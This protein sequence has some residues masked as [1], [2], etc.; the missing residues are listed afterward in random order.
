MSANV[1]AVCV[2]FKSEVMQAIHNL[3]TTGDS[4]KAA[5]Y[6][7]NQGLGGGTT[8]YSTS[9]EVAGTGYIAGGKAVTNGTAWAT[10]GITAY[11]TP[12]ESIQWTGLTISSSFDSWLLYNFSKANRGIAVLTFPAQTVTSGTFTITMPTNAATTALLQVS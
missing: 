3:S 7:A 6:Y 5:L 11:W 10:S 9:G 4:L 2:S 8:T 12:S 1:A